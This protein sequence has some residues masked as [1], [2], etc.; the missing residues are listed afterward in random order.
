MIFIGGIG[1]ENMK[2]CEEWKNQIES[3]LWQDFSEA[4]KQALCQHANL[5]DFCRELLL[6]DF[7]LEEAILALPD[8]IESKKKKELL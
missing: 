6:F 5:C 1:N 7:L 4:E 3:T 2:T 8:M